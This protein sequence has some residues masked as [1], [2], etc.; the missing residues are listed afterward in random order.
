MWNTVRG[1]FL[2]MCVCMRKWP[3]CCFMYNQPICWV[4][5]CSFC[6]QRYL[7]ASPGER[8]NEWLTEKWMLPVS[9]SVKGW[10][11][12][13]WMELYTTTTCVIPDHLAH[14]LAFPA[15][16]PCARQ[17]ILKSEFSQNLMPSIHFFA[18]AHRFTAVKFLN[19]CILRIDAHVD[20]G[21][22]LFILSDVEFYTYFQLYPWRFLCSLWCVYEI[23]SYKRFNKMDCRPLIQQCR[24]ST[25]DMVKVMQ[26]TL[27]ER[28]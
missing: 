27:S 17:R 22:S 28:D 19:T 18:C 7:L 15:I 4:N 9:D 6:L 2:F 14:H 23:Y 8:P 26:S 12:I 16:Q 10:K 21:T 20:C 25:V 3:W 24:L 1:A 11:A 13:L 5:E